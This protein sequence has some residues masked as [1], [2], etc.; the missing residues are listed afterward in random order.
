MMRVRTAEIPGY[1][2]D[3]RHQVSLPCEPWETGY[4]FRRAGKRSINSRTEVALERRDKLMR[5]L[6]KNPGRWYILAEFYDAL[7]E[8]EGRMREDLIAL[9]KAGHVESR[10]RAGDALNRVEWR[11]V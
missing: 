11:A 10:K 1:L 8:T 2:S 4:K 6:S 3:A 7:T 5:F 9:R